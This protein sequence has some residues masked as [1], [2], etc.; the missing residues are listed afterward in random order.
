MS[1]RRYKFRKHLIRKKNQNLRG[2][3]FASQFV[4]SKVGTGC[5][6]NLEHLRPIQADTDM[7]KFPN[8]LSYNTSGGGKGQKKQTGGGHETNVET[9][10]VFLRDN[11]EAAEPG[12]PADFVPNSNLPEQTSCQYVAVV[13]N[14]T[15][16]LTSS[17]LHVD[18]DGFPETGINA[19][20]N[21]VFKTAI[22][23]NSTT[24]SPEQQ[25]GKKRKRISLKKKKN[26]YVKKSRKLKKK[27]GGGKK[28]NV[29]KSLRRKKRK[30]IK[31]RRK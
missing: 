6:S 28:K 15:V 29:R 24:S 20:N 19:S 7:S 27:T 21:T 14:P 17:T 10:P 5:P 4:M 3:S 8:N 9:I 12:K 31:S 30:N 13:Q 2:G 18:V 11:M 25:G 16:E 23:D 22:Q 26:M 1:I